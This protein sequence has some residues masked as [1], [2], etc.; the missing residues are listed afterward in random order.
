MLIIINP[1]NRQENLRED[2][3]QKKGRELRDSD[4]LKAFCISSCSI[5]NESW[6]KYCLRTKNIAITKLKKLD[7]RTDQKTKNQKA[8]DKKLIAGFVQKKGIAYAESNEGV[9]IGWLTNDEFLVF[10]LIGF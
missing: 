10:N 1:E 3:L 2:R 9:K 6:W 7:F 5:G 4:P 8:L